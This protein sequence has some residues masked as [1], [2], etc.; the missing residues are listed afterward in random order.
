[1]SFQNMLGLVA[2]TCYSRN[3]NL[4]REFNIE[5]AFTMQIIKTLPVF[6]DLTYIGHKTFT[7]PF[8]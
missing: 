1:M 4:M 5:S 8:L 2:L 7:Y 6:H 3:M